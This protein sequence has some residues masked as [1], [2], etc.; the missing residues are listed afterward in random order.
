MRNR[1]LYLNHLYLIRILPFQICSYA[2]HTGINK[3]VSK[4]LSKDRMALTKYIEIKLQHIPSQIFALRQ[5]LKACI[6]IRRI[7]YNGLT[8][9]LGCIIRNFF[10]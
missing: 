3:F 7:N 10:K 5:I 1:S 9:V 6:N 4:L 2:E 8:T